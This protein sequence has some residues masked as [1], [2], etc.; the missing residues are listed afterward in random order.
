M[1]DAHA[2]PLENNTNP[3]DKLEFVLFFSNEYFGI[4]V[5]LNGKKKNLPGVYAV[6]FRELLKLNYRIA[7][8]NDNKRL[9]G[10]HPRAFCHKEKRECQEKCVSFFRQIKFSYF[11]ISI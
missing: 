11:C 9:T 10:F 7:L 8:S 5:D 4:K 3:D 2:P 1:S 6:L